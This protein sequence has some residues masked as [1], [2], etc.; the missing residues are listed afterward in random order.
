MSNS[1]PQRTP[2]IYR[3]QTQQS[4]LRRLRWI[5]KLAPTHLT[6]TVVVVVASMDV[7]RKQTIPLQMD[8]YRNNHVSSMESDPSSLSYQLCSAGAHCCRYHSALLVS[9][10]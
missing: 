6:T 3:T 5:L 7:M 9:Y 1:L 4:I 10:E 8:I 2:L